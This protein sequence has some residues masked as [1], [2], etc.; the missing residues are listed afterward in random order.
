MAKAVD[1][2]AH[3]CA[4]QTGIDMVSADFPICSTK[5]GRKIDILAGSFGFGWLV[6]DGLGAVK[7]A[8][9]S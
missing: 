5:T 7:G 3:E 2:Q 8:Q 6:L 4:P 9:M 1:H